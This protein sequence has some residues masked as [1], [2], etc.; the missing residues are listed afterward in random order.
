VAILHAGLFTAASYSGNDADA[1][2]AIERA[3]ELDP[4]NVTF[5]DRL[6]AT[7]RSQNQPGRA[8]A[9]EARLR[10]LVE[11]KSPGR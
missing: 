4:G 9:A 6:V 8:D 10:K 3:S 11:A 5:L 1:L 2:R 7:L